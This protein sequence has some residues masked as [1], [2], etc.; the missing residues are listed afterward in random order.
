ML[1]LSGALT[2]IPAVVPQVMDDDIELIGEQRPE[3]IVQ[4]D[5]QAVAVSQYEPGAIRIAMPPED[6][7]R[8]IVHLRT[9][10]V[11]RGLG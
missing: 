5:R 2:S 1:C 7:D 8:F 4:V 6:D 3:G 9:L 11:E 10:W